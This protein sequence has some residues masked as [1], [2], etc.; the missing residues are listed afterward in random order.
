MSYAVSLVGKR[1]LVTGASSGI[2]RACAIHASRLGATVVL[3]AR[4]IDALEET[5]SRMESPERHLCLACDVSDTITLENLVQ[6]AANGGKLD[7]L[8]HAAGVGPLM[9][10]AFIEYAH[11]EE[12]FR[13]NCASF[14]ILM[15]YFS[16]PKYR[17]G[18]FA[19]VA[20]SSISAFS[21]W[22]GVSAY[23]GSKGALSAVVRS[24]AI[25]LAPKGIRVNAVLPSNIKTPMY[26]A[27]S[28]A[29]QDESSLKALL[30]K[31]PL[32]L[33]EPEQVAAPVCFL[34]S[35]AASFITGVNLP[36]D[37]GYLAQ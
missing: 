15:K 7:G 3:A 10:I 36:V 33:G 18:H 28:A 20:V 4:R 5:R 21:G 13:T 17:N 12:V 9:P 6:N 23:A 22:G 30:A 25:E 32:G 26:E 1:V 19:A 34:L 29:I 16:K 37:G 27:G 24:L 31:Q 2:G 11:L 8:V 14:T 35:D